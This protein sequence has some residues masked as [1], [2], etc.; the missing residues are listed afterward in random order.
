MKCIE[1]DCTSFYVDPTSME[2]V[3][4]SL[5]ESYTKI[6]QP[7]TGITVYVKKDINKFGKKIVAMLSRLFKSLQ[8]SDPTEPCSCR[9]LLHLIRQ[10]QEQKQDQEQALRS[11]SSQELLGMLKLQLTQELRFEQEQAMKYIWL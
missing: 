10:E 5:R 3:L 8:D 1:V 11:G 9:K 4:G 7:N 6:Q 2:C